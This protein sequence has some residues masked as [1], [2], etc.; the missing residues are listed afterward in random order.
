[1]L[2]VDS[3]LLPDGW[4]VGRFLLPPS[5][6]GRDDASLVAPA[7]GRPPACSG[8]QGACR[9]TGCSIMSFRCRAERNTSASRPRLAVLFRHLKHDMRWQILRDDEMH[10]ASFWTNEVERHAKRAIARS[11]GV[12]SESESALGSPQAEGPSR[13]LGSSQL[14]H[15]QTME[16]TITTHFEGSGRRSISN[17]AGISR[18]VAGR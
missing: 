7:Q 10:S 6:I 5:C 13:R 8:L 11:E 17:P 14:H 9:L 18:G 3:P 1:M 4:S 15:L 2:V 12:K 16:P